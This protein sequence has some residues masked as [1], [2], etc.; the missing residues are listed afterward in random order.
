MRRHFLQILVLT[1]SMAT[2]MSIETFREFFIPNLKVAY[3][4]EPWYGIM[5]TAT[6]EIIIEFE[7]TLVTRDLSAKEFNKIYGMQIVTD[8]SIMELWCS[9]LDDAMCEVKQMG[10]YINNNGIYTR[11]PVL[12]ELSHY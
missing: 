5:N 9:P 12:P 8:S 10:S 2:L 1:V 4:K 6:E 7:T 3:A 11:L